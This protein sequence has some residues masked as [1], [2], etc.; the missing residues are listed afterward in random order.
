ML[1]CPC[2]ISLKLLTCNL[3][4]ERCEIQ[5]YCNALFLYSLK[6]WLWF[7]KNYNC[8]SYVS[9]VSILVVLE[10]ET[11]FSVLFFEKLSQEVWLLEE[12]EVL[13][14]Q[15]LLTG[16]RRPM[17]TIVEESRCHR[18]LQREFVVSLGVLLV[19]QA[20]NAPLAH[21]GSLLYRARSIAFAGRLGKLLTAHLF[22]AVSR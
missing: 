7:V 5:N 21:L 3:R 20:D 15:L 4:R 14:V 19:S 18:L 22:L 16:A 6:C 1:P 10:T 2:F 11:A 12:F 9:L 13:A 17:S 8:I